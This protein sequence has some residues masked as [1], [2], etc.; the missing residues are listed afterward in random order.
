M[1]LGQVLFES[2]HDRLQGVNRTGAFEQCQW[3][4]DAVP[5]LLGV[6]HV[7]GVKYVIQP[8]GT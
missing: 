5:T 8:A 4:C 1:G 3:S 6:P 7:A 2:H